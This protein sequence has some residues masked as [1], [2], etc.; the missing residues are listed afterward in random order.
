MASCYDYVGGVCTYIT[1]LV[2]AIKPYV[3]QEYCT[4]LQNEQCS[5]TGI[6]H[7]QP[8]GLVRLLTWSCWKLWVSKSQRNLPVMFPLIVIDKM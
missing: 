2:A 7:H 1:N 3:L 6:A 5:I 8:Q 4:Y